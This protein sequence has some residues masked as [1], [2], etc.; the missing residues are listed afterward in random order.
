M[1]IHHGIMMSSLFYNY[2]FQFFDYNLVILGDRRL[3]FFRMC[4]LIYLT[5]NAT[6]SASGGNKVSVSRAPQASEARLWVVNTHKWIS[7]F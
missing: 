3:K 1:S 5:Y 6:I 2:N 4:I 7:C